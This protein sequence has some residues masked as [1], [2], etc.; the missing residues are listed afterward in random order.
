MLGR[1]QSDESVGTPVGGTSAPSHRPAASPPRWAA[2]SIEPPEANPN[3][4]LI[5]ISGADLATSPRLWRSTGW[6]I[7]P[8]ARRIPNSPKTAP[9]APTDGMSATEHEAGGRAGGRAGEIE[10]PEAQRP[11]P[12]LDDRARKVERIHVERE[13]EQVAVEEGHRPQPPVLA[14]RRR[15]ACRA[16]S[17]SKIAWPSSE[18]SAVSETIA[19]DRDDQQGQRDARRVAA[20]TREVA[21]RRARCCRSPWSASRAG[22]RSPPCPPAAPA[23]LLPDRPGRRRLG[24]RR[25]RGPRRCSARPGTSTASRG[26]RRTG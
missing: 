12:A 7:R 18:K 23:G 4:M 6:W 22:W 1:C 25:G 19:R 5:R 10:R 8:A 14:L 17:G 2:L 9:E 21:L 15:P 13:V 26:A 11:V 24:R 16:A 20:A 3:T